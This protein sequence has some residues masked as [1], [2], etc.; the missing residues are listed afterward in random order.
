LD[1]GLFRQEAI[2]LEERII[3]WRRDFHMHP[4]LGYQEVRTAGI[5]AKTLRELS[6]DVRTGIAETGV[7]ATLSGDKTGATILLR[8]DMDALPIQEETSVPYTSLNP[9]VMHACGHDGHVAIGLAV[10]QMMSHHKEQLKGRLKFVFQP[11]EEGLGGARRMVA[12]GVLE[13]PQPDFCLAAHLWNEKPIDWIGVSAGPIMAGSEI[14]EITI[15]GKGGHGAIPNQ[16]NDPV[17]AAAHLITALQTIVARNIDPRQAGVISVTRVQAGEVFNVIPEKAVLCGTI[18]TFEA[19]VRQ[20]VLQKV[21]TIAKE[22]SAALGCRADVKMEQITPSVVNDE[23]LVTVVQGVA[24]QLF[25]DVNL[26]TE[27]RSMVS[28]DMA[29]MMDTIPGC[30]L[31]IGSGRQG[32]SPSA[33]HHSPLFDIDERA[34]PRAAALLAASAWT[35]LETM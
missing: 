35:I 23:H 27:F 6:F 25:P 1:S 21:E 18:R 7:V 32:E 13:D 15:R 2:R 9:G 31:L 26:A 19:E 11:A 4:E 28:E 22:L 3:A 24:R 30:Y 5:V 20:L 12:E 10:A 17:L 34:L 29:F 14:F 33:P 16:T 8:F